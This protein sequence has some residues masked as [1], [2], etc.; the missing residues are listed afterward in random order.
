M[1]RIGEFFFRPQSLVLVIDIR[2]LFDIRN[3]YIKA[4]NRTAVLGISFD[5]AL[6]IAEKEKKEKKKHGATLLEK[7]VLYLIPSS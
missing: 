6:I 5:D 3:V 1:Y 2:F 4:E 7:I